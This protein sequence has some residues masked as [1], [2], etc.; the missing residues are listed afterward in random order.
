[1]VNITEEEEKQIK[2]AK[3]TK[4]KGSDIKIKKVVV[5]DVW[6]EEYSTQ[7]RKSRDTWKVNK[8]TEGVACFLHPWGKLSDNNKLKKVNLTGK[9]VT[10]RST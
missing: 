6:T 2:N 3:E 5:Q 4:Q 8:V 9:V 10:V 1:M 7:N